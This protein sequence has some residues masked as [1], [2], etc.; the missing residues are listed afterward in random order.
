M[1][2][3]KA[4]LVSAAVILALGIALPRPAVA[5]PTYVHGQI[6]NVTF[7]SDEILIMTC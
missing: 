5:A 4:V 7:S 6:T 1:K 3:S 2:W